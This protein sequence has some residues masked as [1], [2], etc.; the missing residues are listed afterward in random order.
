MG[1]I[2]VMKNNKLKN[3]IITGAL[4]TFLVTPVFVHGEQIRTIAADIDKVITFSHKPDH[5]AKPYVDELTDKYKITSVFEAK[6]L[7][8]AIKLEDFKTLVKL[9]DSNYEGIPDSLTREDVVYELTKIWAE[10][11]GQV[12]ESI[13]V[14]EMLIYSDTDKIDAKYNHSIMVA[15]MKGI[16]K[17]KDARVFDPKANV[18]YGE[19]AT[20]ICNTTKAIENEKQPIIEGKFET[21]GSY[22]I[23]DGKVVFDFELVNYYIEPKQLQFGS[24]QQYEIVITNEE[25]QEVYRYS[26]DKFFTMALIFKTINPGESLKWQD[27]WDMTDKEGNK[28]TSGKYK[29]EI[30]IMARPATEDKKI[31][32]D[33]LS[34]VI[35]F[36][37][38]QTGEETTQAQYKSTEE[39]IIKPEVAKEIIEEIANETILAIK[40]KDAEKLA[41]FVHPIKGVRFTP[42]TYVSVENDVVFSKEEMKDFFNDQ[43]FYLWG[44]YDGTGDEISLTPSQYYEKFI[45]SEDFINAEQIG[46]NEVLSYGNMME[47]QFEVY[48]NAIVVEYYIPGFNPDYEGMDWKSLR[49]VFEKHDDSWKLVGIIHNQWTI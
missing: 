14:I 17:G 49:L 38:D 47:N 35:D 30:K 18:T 19:L 20:L 1:G 6:D 26:D 37:L 33:Q 13:P 46:Y 27:V 48:K 12:L 39:G 21:S 34:T 10:K 8:S 9:I 45:Y 29:A 25:G 40:D 16:A 24:G 15:Y 7:N 3:V 32:E 28:L 44:H 2:I 31:K 36:S 42:Y 41:E 4:C 5:W 43:K 22:E 11:T 23:K